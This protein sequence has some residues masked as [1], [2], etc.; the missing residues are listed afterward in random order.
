MHWKTSEQFYQLTENIDQVFWIRNETRE[1]IIYVSPAYEKVWGRSCQSLY[2]NP[3]SFREAIHPDDTERITRAILV[4]RTSGIFDEAYRIV[5]P[6]NTIRWIRARTFPIQGNI[7]H[8]AG[9]ADDITEQRRMQEELRQSEEHYRSMVM[10]LQ[11]GIVLQDADG[12]I[13]ICNPSA[14]HILG[15]SVEQIAGRTSLDPRWHAIREDETPFDG[16]DHPAMV[17]LRTGEPCTNVVMG[18]HKPDGRLTWISINSRPLIH[19][20]ETSPYAV[21]SSFTDITTRRHAERILQ[22]SYEE[23]DHQVRERTRELEH[24][25][26]R[27]QAEV[28]ERKQIERELRT[29][30][31]TLRALLNAIRESVLI[32]DT[33]TAILRMCSIT[34]TNNFA[35]NVIGALIQTA[36]H[37]Y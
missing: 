16:V 8:Y 19:P 13:T 25:N 17:T 5:R 14:E 1:R 15:L 24:A 2:E 29:S 4:Y 6:D 3:E 10:L 7:W 34:L 12:N 30:E 36:Q 11:E 9:I 31:E 32:F 22:E 23:L 18:V 20:D 33:T 35:Y 21:V 26:Q 37:S 28:A 27:L